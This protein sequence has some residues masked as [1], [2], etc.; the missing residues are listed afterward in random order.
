MTNRFHT[1]SF[2][3]ILTVIPFAMNSCA[4]SGT[5][6]GGTDLDTL[7]IENPDLQLKD[8]LKRLSGVQVTDSGNMVRVVIRG[9]S[10]I[11]TDTAP[12]YVIDGTQI[13]TS[14]FDA[15]NSVNMRDVDYI[16]ILR[17]SEAMTTYGMRA[18][19]GAI[20]IYTKQ[21]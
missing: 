19:H 6:R 16:R 12:L 10:S 21:N 9:S 13:G 15:A 20:V 5:A 3:L 11:S 4:T 2:L 18:A 17:S 8:Y 14:Y 1:L 7:L